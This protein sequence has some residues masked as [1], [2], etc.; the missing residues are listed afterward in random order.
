MKSLFIIVFLFI[1]S[2][3]GISQTIE[4]PNFAMASHPMKVTKVE[5][6]ET[7]T[8]IELSIENQ[9]ITGEFC[10]DKN[11][12][13]QDALSGLKF[14]LISSKGIP[15]CPASYKFKNVGE[16]LTFQL[17]FPQINPIF[18][19]LTLVEDCDNNCFSVVGIILDDEFNKE[20]NMGFDYY[21]KGKLDFALV[22]F[23]K[24]IEN[25]L[26]YPFG[27]L[28]LNVIQILSEKKDYNNAKKW[29]GKLKNS[30]FPDKQYVIDRLKQQA[31]YKQLIF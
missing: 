21:S 20:I 30:I 16:V 6:L 29:Y 23:K 13:V 12:Y 11:I 2:F 14:Q 4:N 10:A 18:K 7:Q 15:V 1:Y 31:Y 26:E 19:Y 8:L 25:H 9:S 17:Y 24:A 22:A 28:Y 3:I 5:Y 27:F